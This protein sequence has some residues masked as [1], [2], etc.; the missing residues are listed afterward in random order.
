[1]EIE[2]RI[3]NALEYV[4]ND[5]YHALELF[6]GILQEQPRNVNALNGKGSALM[7]LHKNEEALKFFD[8]SLSIE[9]N[10]SAYLNKG[11]IAKCNKDYRNALIYFDKSLEFNPGLSSIV[12]I[13]KNEILETVDLESADLDSLYDFSEEA[14]RLIKEAITYRKQLR[15]WD[16]LDSLEKAIEED[17]TC[18]NSVNDLIN[19][20]KKDLQKEFLYNEDEFNK[21]AN[22]KD[23]KTKLKTKK[24]NKLKALTHRSLTVENNPHKALSL[25][26]KI[27]EMNPKDLEAHNFQGAAYFSLN[28]YEKAIESFDECLRINNNYHCALFNK[29]LVLRRLGFLK[30]SLECFDKALKNPNHYQKVKPYQEEVLYKLKLEE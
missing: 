9:E 26:N 12:S 13:L 27:F 22:S 18:S 8:C 17:P 14:N 29:G 7:K 16:A 23:K 11:I 1:M 28:E 15:I 3:E 19:K 21:A 20:V 2:S 24:I 10:S 5:T 4:Q 30:E 25:T 6:N